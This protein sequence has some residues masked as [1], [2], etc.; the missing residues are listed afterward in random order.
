VQKP[1]LVILVG[2]ISL[3]K[4]RWDMLHPQRERLERLH[5]QCPAFGHEVESS[6]LEAGEVLV[7]EP[8]VWAAL[9]LVVA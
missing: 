5:L 8:D 1:Q 6:R 9:G 7:L 3:K 4:I 2:M